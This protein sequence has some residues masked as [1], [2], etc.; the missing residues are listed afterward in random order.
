MKT[1]HEDC[2]KRLHGN[3]SC[4]GFMQRAHA[5]VSCNDFMQRLCVRISN[6]AAAKEHKPLG[7]I[8]FVKEGL[9]Q[10]GSQYTEENTPTNAAVPHKQLDELD[11]LMS[12]DASVPPTKDELSL[13]EKQFAQM[14]ED[15][16]RD[17]AEQI[18]RQRVGLF[19]YGD[20]DLVQKINDLQHVKDQSSMIFFYHPG[21]HATKVSRTNDVRKSP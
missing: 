1:L 12:L 11:A 17:V 9:L 16:Y 5:P 15:Y 4:N 13:L 6:E 20:K 2:M 21:L 3:A 14:K 10:A 19:V 7:D 18:V 8:S